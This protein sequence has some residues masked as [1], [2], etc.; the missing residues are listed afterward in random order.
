MLVILYRTIPTCSRLYNRFFEDMSFKF[1]YGKTNIGVIIFLAVI[2]TL[3]VMV[4]QMRLIVLDR[5]FV[6][7]P[8]KY[9]SY[10]YSQLSNGY[11]EI[12]FETR[13]GL[14]LH[15]IF[16]ESQSNLTVIL[17]HG[18]AGN[19]GDR[20]GYL[21]LM[22]S[23]LGVNVFL[24]DYRGYGLS[25]GTPSESGLYM[26]AQAAVDL[27]LVRMNSTNG[28]DSKLVLFGRSLGSSVALKM[29]GIYKPSSVIIEGP[30]TSITDLSRK[31]Y[32]YVPTYVIKSLIRARYESSSM[33]TDIS[34]PLMVIHG[35]EDSI[36]PIDMGKHIYDLATVEKN[37]YQV[38]GAGHN[39]TYVVA[40][41]EYF[42]RIRAFIA[43][44]SKR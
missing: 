8:T 10:D 34:C 30:F 5:L 20:L 19:I 39:D 33:V 44:K 21:S 32:P 17:F 31:A 40:G 41:S 2:L 29:A 4:Y 28:E 27:M 9:A 38:E 3:L 11:E 15:G 24:F 18:N 14:I 1:S 37:F 22:S 6:Y 16:L 25:E 43:D 42:G 36:V 23:E 7:F 12:F 26:D 35:D 13:D